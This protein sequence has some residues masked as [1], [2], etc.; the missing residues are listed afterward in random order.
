MSSKCSTRSAIREADLAER[1]GSMEDC[2]DNQNQWHAPVARMRGLPVKARSPR[3]VDGCRVPSKKEVP[4]EAILELRKLTKTYANGRGARDISFCMEPGGI[5]GLLGANGAGK[6]TVMKMVA[7]LLPPDGGML[8]HRGAEH[9]QGTGALLQDVGF[10]VEQPE[11]FGY[12]TA[13]ENLMQKARFY[14]DGAASAERALM[15]VG[16]ADHRHEKVKTFSMGMK[17]RLGLAFALTGEPSLLVLDEPTN[18]MDIEGRSDFRDLLQVLQRERGLSVLLSSHL[19]SELEQ[20]ADH[21]VVL[22]EGV[23]VATADMPVI[24]HAGNTLEQW[25][26]QVVRGTRQTPEVA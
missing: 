5:T 13:W 17:Q 6:S 14:S 15:Q 7:G 12:L 25:Y 4:V 1:A 9:A 10:M 26:L 23:Q 2:Q 18:G 22:H 11:A 3:A 21:V 24:L 19:V 16:L 20:L 8:C